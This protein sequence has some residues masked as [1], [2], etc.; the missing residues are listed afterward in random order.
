MNFI[1]SSLLLLLALLWGGCF[2]EE[3]EGVRLVFWTDRVFVEEDFEELYINDKYIGNLMTHQTRPLCSDSLL[4]DYTMTRSE[5][6]HLSVKNM[7]GMTKD[8]GVVDLYSVSMG[9][10]IKPAANAD[11]FVYQDLD[12]ICT[13]V[14]IDWK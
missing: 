5:D 1:F 2:L 10:R 12:D 9:I 7:S 13:L 4:L 11:I 6:L 14:E 8:I 3:E